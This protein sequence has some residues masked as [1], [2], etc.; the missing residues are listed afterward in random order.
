MAEQKKDDEV[1]FS[2][3]LRR[4]ISERLSMFAKQYSTGLGK[5]DY[6]VA[7]QILLDFYEQNSTVAQTNQ[8]LDML[9]GMVDELRFQPVEQ[10]KEK[11]ED[12]GIEML[13]GERLQR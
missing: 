4:D 9:L 11:E 10:E 8:K 12:T 3:V 1:Y 5:W 2:T 13:G 7:F 6:G